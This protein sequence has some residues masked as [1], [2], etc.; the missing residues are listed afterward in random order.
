MGA[1]KGEGRIKGLTPKKGMKECKTRRWEEKGRREHS[2]RKN[3]KTGN[4]ERSI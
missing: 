3:G 2:R 4:G 1:W